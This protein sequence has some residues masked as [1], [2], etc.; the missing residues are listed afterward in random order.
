MTNARVACVMELTHGMGVVLMR[1]HKGHASYEKC[2]SPRL[3][4]VVEDDR[5]WASD[6]RQRTKHLHDADRGSVA[7]SESD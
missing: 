7:A 2:G 6:R 3:H 4:S 1:S 5:C